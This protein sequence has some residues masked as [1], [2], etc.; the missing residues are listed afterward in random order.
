MQHAT[1]AGLQRQQVQGSPRPAAAHASPGTAAGAPA[2]AP[3]GKL[4]MFHGMNADLLAGT[5]GIAICLI[6]LLSPSS[7]PTPVFIALGM[8]FTNAICP[9]LLALAPSF[10]ARHRTAVVLLARLSFMHGTLQRGRR[11]GPGSAAPLVGPPCCS[12][13][14][15]P[16]APWSPAGARW[17]GSCPCPCI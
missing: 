8:V 4:A 16:P 17:P 12:L 10:Y 11:S 6:F 7:P 1:A 3:A 2:R 9:V 14:L 15:T 13:L 5:T